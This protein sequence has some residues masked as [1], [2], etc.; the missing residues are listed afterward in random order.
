MTWLISNWHTVVPV[1]LAAES[2]IMP[3]VP[4]KYN[5]LVHTI[6]ATITKGAN[7]A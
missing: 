7:P 3:H 5:G 2:L 1:A 4:V 6:L